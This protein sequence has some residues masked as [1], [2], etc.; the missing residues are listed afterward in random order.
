MSAIGPRSSVSP[1]E[2][3]WDESIKALR[4]FGGKIVAAAERALQGMIDADGRLIPV[5]VRATVDRRR[6]D[7]SRD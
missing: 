4:Q 3:R 5:P 6:P 7:Q 2:R 1:V